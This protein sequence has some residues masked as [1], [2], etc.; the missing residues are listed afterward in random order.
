M[1]PTAPQQPLLSDAGLPAAAAPGGLTLESFRK[2]PFT[3][4]K[5]AGRLHAGA[6][7]TAEAEIL[8]TIVMA[9][10]PLRLVLDLTE[11]T[12]VDFHGKSLLTKTRFTVQA[13]RGTLLVV[14]PDDSPVHRI[15][16]LDVV[17]TPVHLG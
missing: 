13:G 17:S 2:G 3:V 12:S 16:H 5:M 7:V 9:P 11:V 15:P 4:V 8:S 6:A 14:A 10:R 1:K